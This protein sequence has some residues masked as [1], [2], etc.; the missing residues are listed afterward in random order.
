MS[1]GGGRYGEVRTGI[2]GEYLTE[3][4]GRNERW[5]REGGEGSKC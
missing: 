4:S 1:A 2:G 5:D 3:R